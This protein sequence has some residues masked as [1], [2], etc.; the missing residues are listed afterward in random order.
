MGK[1]EK[2][3]MCGICGKIHLPSQRCSDVIKSRREEIKNLT[4]RRNVCQ[5]K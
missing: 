5:T 1:K 3:I 4:E 2:N